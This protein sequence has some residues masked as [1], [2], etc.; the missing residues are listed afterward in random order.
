MK[1]IDC[2]HGSE[3]WHAARC[4]RATAS[5]ISDIMRKRK[6]GKPSDMRATYA[7]ELVAERLSG[8]VEPSFT[9][10]AMQ[11]GL[12]TEDRARAHYGFITDSTPQRVGLVI[13]PTIEMAAASPDRLVGDDGLLEIK[14]PHS[15]THISTLLGARIEPDYLKQIHW[16]LACTGRS[17][18]DYVS[19]DDRLP[20]EMAIHIQRVHR[21]DTI[22]AEMETEVRAFLAEVDETVRKLTDM[23]RAEAA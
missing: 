11:H 15:R 5:R 13:H 23:Y 4:G 6:D 22:I 18:C 21:D 10:S 20:P 3:E 17:W 1:V 8:R 19:F 9:S 7:G 2:E 14:C 16:Q 12:D